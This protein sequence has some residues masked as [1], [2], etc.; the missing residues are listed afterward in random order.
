MTDFWKRRAMDTFQECI[1]GVFSVTTQN[2]TE[3]N[4]K[5]GRQWYITEKFPI[6]AEGGI[7]QFYFRLGNSPAIVKYRAISTNVVDLD[8]EVYVQPTVTSDGTPVTVNNA[9]GI[10]QAP[11]LSEVY[12]DPTISDIG[13]LNERAWIPGSEGAGNRTIGSF[14]ADGFEKIIPPNAEIVTQFVNNGLVSGEVLY[15][16]VVYEGPIA[17]MGAEDMHNPFEVRT[18]GF[19]QYP[20]YDESQ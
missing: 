5:R 15:L 9:N 3:L 2:F 17:P 1:G 4:A 13:T 10:Y 11:F 14:A 20:G 12:E 16:L 8:Y 7:K 6:A 18:P 19:T